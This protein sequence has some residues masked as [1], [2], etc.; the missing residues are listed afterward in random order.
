MGII[1]ATLFGGFHAKKDYVISYPLVDTSDQP[2]PRQRPHALIYGE[3]FL[4]TI[5]YRPRLQSTCWY[6]SM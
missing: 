3:H 5:N 2:Q 6:L 4:P 1:S